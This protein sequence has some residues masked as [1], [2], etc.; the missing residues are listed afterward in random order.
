[1]EADTSGSR[2]TG[3]QKWNKIL[4]E[5]QILL[6]C[7]KVDKLPI[8]ITWSFPHWIL[9]FMYIY[10]DY[11]VI[12]VRTEIVVKLEFQNFIIVSGI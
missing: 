10:K 2:I 9:E 8:L 1:M 12:S 7:F 3:L 6:F 5:F 4:L 11:L